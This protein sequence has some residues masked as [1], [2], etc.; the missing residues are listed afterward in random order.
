MTLQNL[1]QRADARG[2]T[3]LVLAPGEELPHAERGPNGDAWLCIAAEENTPELIS[4]ATAN[5]FS[6]VY[7][8]EPE[9]DDGAATRE[10]D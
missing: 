7:V 2:A 1:R 10:Q 6:R 4:A 9:K 5:G 8:L 3:L